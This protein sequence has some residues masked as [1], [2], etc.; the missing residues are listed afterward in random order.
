MLVI[1]AS[2]MFYTE[3]IL[4]S[5]PFRYSVPFRVC[6]RAGGFVVYGVHGPFVHEIQAEHVQ[7]AQ[8]LSL[9]L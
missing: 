6:M 4:R 7:A 1:S 9:N 5:V 8:Y 2:T 3:W